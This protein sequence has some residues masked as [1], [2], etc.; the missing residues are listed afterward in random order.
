M[1]STTF[2]TWGSVV[3]IGL[4]SNFLS[5]NMMIRISGALL[6]ASLFFIVTNFGVWSLGSY[7]YTLNS[8]ILCY[9]LALPFFGYSLISTLLFSVIIESGYKFFQ[10]NFISRLF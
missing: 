5:T 7:G 6:G 8:L 3:M 4:I 1:H 10:K 9:T 2:F